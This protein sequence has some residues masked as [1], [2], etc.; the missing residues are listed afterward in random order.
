MTD[1][2]GTK[3]THLER[4][5]PIIKDAEG[6]EVFYNSKLARKLDR[7]GS[8]YGRVSLVSQTFNDI[9]SR[10]FKQENLK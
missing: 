8:V 6:N 4:Y 7:Q 10:K 1:Y 2:N 5:Q 3:F 9:Q